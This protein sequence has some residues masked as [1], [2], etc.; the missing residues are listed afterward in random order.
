MESSAFLAS[1]LVTMC[2]VLRNRPRAALLIGAATIYLRPE[3]VLL[4]V[5]AAV[6]LVVAPLDP[7][8]KLLS[9]AFA[10]LVIGCPALLIRSY[11]GA[12]LPHSIVAKST[13]RSEPGEVLAMFFWP[14]GSPLQTAFTIAAPIA[15]AL[16]WRRSAFLRLFAAWAIVYV[17]AYIVRQPPM[18]TWY[19]LPFYALKAVIAGAALAFVFEHYLPR[20]VP[21][22]RVQYA[23]ALVSSGACAL[24]LVAVFGPS[25]VRIH[26]YAP[27]EDWCTANMAGH[28]TIA[29]ADIGAIGYYC[30]AYIIDL[31]GLVW[32]DRYHRH[33]F[34]VPRRIVELEKPDFVLAQVSDNW[35]SLFD[36][37]APLRQ[38]YR[39]VV[40]F[41]KRGV[42]DVNVPIATLPSLW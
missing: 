31:S 13:M 38:M 33:R 19:A 29:A 6:A 34:N 40:R 4:L 20:R 25:P 30:N 2:L 16:L 23:G 10:C 14:S 17:T 22:E 27:M 28:Q 9:A 36:P 39:P 41:S 3:G 37:R 12:F 11:Y 5:V 24:A 18:W 7:R 1:S 26:I 15:L 8:R 42:K 21:A 32:P 35:I